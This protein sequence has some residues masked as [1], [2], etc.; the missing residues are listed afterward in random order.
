MK[1]R[2]RPD[3]EERVDLPVSAALQ[4][5]RQQAVRP[6]ERSHRDRQAGD[7]RNIQSLHKAKTKIGRSGSCSFCRR[8]TVHI[9]RPVPTIA[10]PMKLTRK[11]SH[12]NSVS[13]KRP[14]CSA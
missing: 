2:Q 12:R 7:A 10:V 1:Q 3:D 5:V 9:T 13:L 14:R 4:R 8:L 6:Q 11:Y